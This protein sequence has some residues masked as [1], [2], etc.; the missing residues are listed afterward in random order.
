MGCA[1]ALSVSAILARGMLVVAGTFGEL[2][3]FVLVSMM[4]V[5]VVVTRRVY[6]CAQPRARSPRH[7][8]GKAPRLL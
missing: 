3:L 8:P 7:N 4:P 5:I 6:W 2:N 1:G